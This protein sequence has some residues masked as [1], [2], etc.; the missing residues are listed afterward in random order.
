MGK[1]ILLSVS[2]FWS[3]KWGNKGLCGWFKI[4]SLSSHGAKKCWL[5]RACN[6][7][8]TGI[9]LG[10]NGIISLKFTSITREMTG[11]C[12]E[13]KT[14]SGPTLKGHFVSTPWGISSVLCCSTIAFNPSFCLILL[15]LL[16]S[17]CHSW[18]HAPKHFVHNR[19]HNL[20][21]YFLENWT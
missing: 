9:A 21:I 8:P 14:S 1:L 3:S 5:L 20:R 2:V 7:V 17:G 11:Q 4:K 16:P 15:S 6:Q 18:E 10:L 12:K 19:K 13:T